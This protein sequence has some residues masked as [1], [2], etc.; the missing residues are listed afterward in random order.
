MVSVTIY[1]KILTI[2][3]HVVS[4]MK[5][6]QTRGKNVEYSII[7]EEQSIKPKQSESQTS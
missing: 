2:M 7:Y 3:I 4:R 5:H 6:N 1:E